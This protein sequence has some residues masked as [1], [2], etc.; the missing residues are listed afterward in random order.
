MN[1]ATISTAVQKHPD[2]ILMSKKELQDKVI[3]AVEAME[4]AANETNN[5]DIFKK[6]TVGFESLKELIN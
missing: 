5:L 6:L 4:D 1:N 3:K 2:L